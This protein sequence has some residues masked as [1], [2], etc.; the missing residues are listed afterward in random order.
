MGYFDSLGLFTEIIR[1]ATDG[2]G[3]GAW[4]HISGNINGQ[5]FS[6]GPGGWDSRLS[7]ADYARRQVDKIHR[8]GRGIIL[9]LTPAQEGKLVSCLR[10]QRG[11]YGGVSN[12]CGTPWLSCLQELGVVNANDKARVLPLDVI[13]IIADSPNATGQTNY[14]APGNKSFDVPPVRTLFDATRRA[15]S[16]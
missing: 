10:R 6:W 15:V 3:S 12:N 8:D 1:W 13:K 7:A 9:G 16:H 5:N 11:A 14:S 4:G 2:S